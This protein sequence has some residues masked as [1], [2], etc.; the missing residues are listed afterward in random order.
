MRKPREEG[1]PEDVDS[2]RQARRERRVAEEE[3]QGVSAGEALRSRA[4]WVVSILLGSMLFGTS[5][6]QVHQVP[7]FESK[8]F[9]TAEAAT[10]VSLV[11]LLSGVG[12]IGAGLLTDYLE[13][14]HVLAI[15]VIMQVVG[16]TYLIVY[17]TTTLL[18]S[19]PFTLFYGVSFGAMVSIRPV[20]LAQL[21]GTRSLGSLSGMLQA[22]A[23]ASGTIGPVFMGW[24]FDI[25]Q[26]YD[27]ALITFIV[28]TAIGFPLAYTIRPVGSLA[29]RRRRA[30]RLGAR[31]RG[32]P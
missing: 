8:G 7:F 16:W 11:F 10:T 9:S 28:T 12:R 24:I 23:L 26:A 3:E 31:M 32:S 6:I 19:V 17:G 29:E 30:R 15:M 25:N 21:F 20:L 4:F 5:A 14:R 1:L 18:A 27:A 13:V 2:D 22:T